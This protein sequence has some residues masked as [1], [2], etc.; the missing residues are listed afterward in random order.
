MASMGRDG[1]PEGGVEEGTTDPSGSAQELARQTTPELDR[2]PPPAFPPGNRRI[3]TRPWK[4][5]PS[6]EEDADSFFPEGALISPDDPV[7]RIGEELPD[8]ALISPDDP[9]ERR[10]PREGELRPTGGG[11]ADVRSV[12]SGE[13]S[14]PSSSGDTEDEWG[15]EE[16]V[17]TGIGSDGLVYYEGGGDPTRWG[18]EMDLEQVARTLEVLAGDLK[19]R[20]AAALMVDRESAPLEAG[21]RGLLSGFLLGRDD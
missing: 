10:L 20:G 7:R 1:D 19:E 9:I 5:K 12:Q 21:L 2:L 15:E 11:K 14:A 13:S 4:R 18:T 17:V 16:A 3:P 6:G 8:D